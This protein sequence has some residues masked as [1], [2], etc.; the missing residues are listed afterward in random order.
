MNRK[1]IYHLT[2]AASMLFALAACGGAG[3]HRDAVGEDVQV[4]DTTAISNNG[5]PMDNLHRE[6]T[7]DTLKTEKTETTGVPMSNI[8][9][10]EKNDTVGQPKMSTE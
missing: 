9:R 1:T 3:E 2:A 8:D 5:V 6:R 7:A 10:T 4:T